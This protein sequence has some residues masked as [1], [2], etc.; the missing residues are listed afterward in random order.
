MRERTDLLWL[1]L[2]VIF[3]EEGSG[4]TGRLYRFVEW[5]TIRIGLPGLASMDK[6]GYLFFLQVIFSLWFKGNFDR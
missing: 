3:P 1:L 4:R 2:P 5:M 6:Y